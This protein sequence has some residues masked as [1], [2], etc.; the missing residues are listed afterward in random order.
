MIAARLQSSKSCRHLVPY[1]RRQEAD[2]MWDE[3]HKFIAEVVTALLICSFCGRGSFEGTP[4]SEG[5][6]KCVAAEKQNP[7]PFLASHP[8]LAKFVGTFKR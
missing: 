5:R 4:T 6:F 7:P 8:F 1:K 3:W 2:G